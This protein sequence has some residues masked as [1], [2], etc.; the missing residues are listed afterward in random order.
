MIEQI[1]SNPGLSVGLSGL[2]VLVTALLAG[3]LTLGIAD[4]VAKRPHRERPSVV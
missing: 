4:L 3:S 2:V 1:L